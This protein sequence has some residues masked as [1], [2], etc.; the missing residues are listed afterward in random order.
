MTNGDVIR[1]MSNEELAAAMTATSIKF[2][3]TFLPYA[4]LLSK[5]DIRDLY[6]SML[7]QINA[8]VD[9]ELDQN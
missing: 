4:H 9:N 2:T 8:E 3:N 5:S 6:E 1:Q 7:E